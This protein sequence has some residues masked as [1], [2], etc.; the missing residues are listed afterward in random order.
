MAEVAIHVPGAVRAVTRAGWGA[1]WL[2]LGLAVAVAAGC[3]RSSNEWVASPY[4]F[5]MAGATCFTVT[6]RKDTPL[7]VCRDDQG[8]TNCRIA[9]KPLFA[10]GWDRLRQSNGRCRETRRRQRWVADWRQRIVICT[11]GRARE[12]VSQLFHLTVTG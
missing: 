10:R 7:A 12:G 11:T 6:H 4:W 2:S 3:G 8:S 9:S 1:A 5:K